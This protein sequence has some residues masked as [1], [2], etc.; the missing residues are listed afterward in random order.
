METC[1]LIYDS[2]CPL[3]K[4]YT[5]AFQ[6]Q[7]LLQP[8]ERLSF[9]DAEKNGI[10]KQVDFKRARHEIALVHSRT[11]NVSYGIDALSYIL[12]RKF[13]RLVPLVQLPVIKPVLLLLYKFISYNRRVIP[14]PVVSNEKYS[15]DLN[16]PYR[17]AY[18]VFAGAIATVIS[19]LLG[20]HTGWL[21]SGSADP[22]WQMVLTVGT[23]WMLQ[24]IFSRLML[25]A[26][27]WW[28]YAGNLFTVMLTGVLL[29][30]PFLWL[31]HF[32]VLPVWAVWVAI[33]LSQLVMC[34]QH[35][36]RIR[37]LH[38]S[39]GLFFSW[40]IFLAVSFIALTQLL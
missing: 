36:M 11:G 1:Y 28:H 12:A 3:C 7:G 34:Y 21:F 37:A 32:I 35:W 30:L 22:G 23:G 33:A 26:V 31:N 27:T 24:L 29:L 6:Q 20:I 15:P 18:L 5:G 17:V 39:P 38:L 25:G 13:P 9:A 40:W 16:V 10:L 4:A 2:D 19:Y 14:V 8:D